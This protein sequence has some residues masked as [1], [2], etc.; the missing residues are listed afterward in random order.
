MNTQIL[1]KSPKFIVEINK[2]VYF[3]SM[4]EQLS[5]LKGIHPGQFLDRELRRRS[6][7]SKELAFAIGEHP[8]TLSAIIRGRRAMNTPLS[9][10]IERNLQLEEGLLMSLQVFFEIEQEKRKQASLHCPD[11]NKFRPALFWDTT[12]DRIDWS[13]NRRYAI[14]RIFERGTE[15][16]ILEAIRFYGTDTI[17]HTLNEYDSMHSVALQENINKYIFHA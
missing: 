13:N 11:L 6:I 1:N 8:Q 4:N 15:S 17:R 9:L 3:C 16:E 5:I 12:L 10:R 14:Q 7:K 2:N